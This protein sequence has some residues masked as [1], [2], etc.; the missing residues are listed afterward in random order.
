MAQG[1]LQRGMACVFRL[2]DG[3]FAV[4]LGFRLGCMISGRPLP[5]T[6][7]AQGLSWASG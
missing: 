3:G 6:A 2:R 4:I 1:F 7:K 5:C